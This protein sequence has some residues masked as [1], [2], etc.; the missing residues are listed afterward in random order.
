MLSYIGT[1]GYSYKEWCGPFYPEGTRPPQMLGYYAG[2]LKAVEINNTFYRMPKR[3]VL[4]G[5][6][7]QVPEEFRFVLKVTRRITHF[8][9]LKPETIEEL[10]YVLETSDALGDRRG[11]MLF[12]LPPNFKKDAARLRG[13]LDLL[14][15]GFRGAFEFRDPSWFDGE[16]FEALSEHGLALVVADTGTDQD[17]PFQRTADYGYL[18]LRREDYSEADLGEWA[19]RISAQGWKEVFVFFKHEDGGAGPRMAKRFESLLDG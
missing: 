9:R 1:S 13:F 17:P 7:E 8:K 2:Q 15:A 14:P 4:A 10:T 3:E 18:R 19:A 5:W 6:A 16:V 12:Q 11:P